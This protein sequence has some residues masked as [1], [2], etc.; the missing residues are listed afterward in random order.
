MPICVAVHHL[1]DFDAWFEVF[2][3]NPPPSVGRWRVLRGS[4]DPN[5]V[6]VVGEFEASQVDEIKSF[7]ASDKMQAVFNEVDAMST[8][9]LEFVWLD[10]VTP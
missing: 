7:L 4:N 5:R 6:H 3:S 2:K 9:P 10:D 8:E 1:K